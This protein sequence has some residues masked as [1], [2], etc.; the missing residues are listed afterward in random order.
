MYLFR[1]CAS[2]PVLAPECYSQVCPIQL[3]ACGT[4]LPYWANLSGKASKQ[5]KEATGTI[6]FRETRRY[7]R[8]LLRP[9]GADMTPRHFGSQSAFRCA[10]ATFT[11][12]ESLQ[13]R[14]LCPSHA[15]SPGFRTH[16]DQGDLGAHK[17]LISQEVKVPQRSLPA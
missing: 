17:F 5:W 9:D 8:N 13:V 12:K 4:D 3:D 11:L 15:K 14:F 10:A 16:P 6:F 1:V 7:A 2:A